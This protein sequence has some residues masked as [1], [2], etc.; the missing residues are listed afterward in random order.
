MIQ[1]NPGSPGFLLFFLA[2]SH[3]GLRRNERSVR[4]TDATPVHAAGQAG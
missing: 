2:S 4:A 3:T 1:Q